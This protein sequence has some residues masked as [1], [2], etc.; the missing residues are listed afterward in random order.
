MAVKG[1]KSKKTSAKGTKGNP[2]R[3][4]VKTQR[5]SPK[6]VS[7]FKNE[8]TKQ[9]SKATLKANTRIDARGGG[10]TLVANGREYTKSAPTTYSHNIKKPKVRVTKNPLGKVSPKQLRGKVAKIVQFGKY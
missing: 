6:E 5:I 8:L 3:T 2:T 4:K 9:I 7:N 10:Y 1:S